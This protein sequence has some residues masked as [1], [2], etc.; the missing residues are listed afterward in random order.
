MRIIKQIV[1][2]IV[3]TQAMY[4]DS[5]HEPRE[6]DVL[7]WELV[8]EFGVQRVVGMV[9]KQGESELIEAPSYQ[10]EYTDYGKFEGYTHHA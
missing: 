5:K 6:K 10:D 2:A 9:G 1:S 8:E 3:G 4:R 7:V